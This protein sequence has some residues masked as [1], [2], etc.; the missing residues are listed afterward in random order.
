MKIVT[1]YQGKAHITSNDDQGRNQGIFGTDSYV[2]SVGQQFAATLVNSNELD[3][4][5]GEGVMQGVHFRIEPGEVDAAKLQNGTSGMKRIDLVVARYTKD[6]S[7]GIENVALVVIKGTE[8]SSTPAVPAYNSGEILKGKNTVDFPLY[9]VTY[10][11]INVSSVD[12][13]FTKLQT[14]AELQ[15]AVNKLNTD[16]NQNFESCAE[17]YT[18]VRYKHFAYSIYARSRRGA[19]FHIAAIN[20][21]LYLVWMFNTNELS[22]TK[23]GNGTIQK[24]TGDVKVDSVRFHRANNL[25]LEIATDNDNVKFDITIYS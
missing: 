17:S 22:V 11:G 9:K 4:A 19:K 13:M 7:T 12:R 6:S 15:T 5:D 25:Y 3:I 1:G 23:L 16:F 24:G 18:C 21:T 14:M 20:S 2:T 10:N 8:S